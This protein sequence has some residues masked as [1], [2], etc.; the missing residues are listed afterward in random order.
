MENNVI[1]FLANQKQRFNYNNTF[2]AKSF[3][4]DKSVAP[5]CDCEGRKYF[6]G[7]SIIH[8][9]ELSD[10][11]AVITKLIYKKDGKAEVVL[12]MSIGFDKYELKQY[13]D[14]K[15][16]RKMV[17]CSKFHVDDLHIEIPYD[18]DMLEDFYA[19]FLNELTNQCT[20]GNDKM[21]LGSISLMYNKDTFIKEKVK[22][23]LKQFLEVEE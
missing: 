5:L 3:Y 18:D 17:G 20:A 9:S 23:V 2:Q 21:G 4:G 14:S 22:D 11:S 15:K 13:S 7:Y 6:K 16:E 8:R 1:N 10:I 19:K 12:T